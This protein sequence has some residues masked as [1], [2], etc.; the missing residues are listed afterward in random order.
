MADTKTYPGLMEV[1]D[2]IFWDEFNQ[3]DHPGDRY[4]V[5]DSKNQTVVTQNAKLVRELKK[6]RV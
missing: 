6:V 1:A 4:I 3:M 5:I 2:Q